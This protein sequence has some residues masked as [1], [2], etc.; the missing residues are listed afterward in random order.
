V[1]ELSVHIN[2]SQGLRELTDFS[3]NGKKLIT[4]FEPL[5]EGRYW[6]NITYGSETTIFQK[7]INSQ[8][9]SIDVFME[10]GL[11]GSNGE[12]RTTWEVIL[13]DDEL[14]PKYNSLVTIHNSEN[15]IEVNTMETGYSFTASNSNVELNDI[16]AVI[17][18]IDS[19]G[20]YSRFNLNLSSLLINSEGINNPV[21]SF[22][23]NNLV[24]I[25]GS[26]IL[27]LILARSYITKR[28]RNISN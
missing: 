18:I 9:P 10:K 19:L 7:E 1:N 28:K 26:L 21:Y 27:I 11:S 25:V 12:I 23:E 17:E 3:I 16:V 24:L 20:Q 13:L 15:E 8:G 2:S 14:I 4:S 22:I 5:I 6:V